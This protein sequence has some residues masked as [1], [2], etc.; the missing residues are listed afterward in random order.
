[1]RIGNLGAVAVSFGVLMGA[2]LTGCAYDEAAA[3]EDGALVEAGGL[4]QGEA[5]GEVSQALDSC[6]SSESGGGTW[7]GV[8]VLCRTS[9]GTLYVRKHDNGTFT[10]SGVMYLEADFANTI[11][12]RNVSDGV[13][14]VSFGWKPEDWY[15]ATYYPSSVGGIAYT[16]WLRN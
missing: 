2:T 9:T 4:E 12:S 7:G 16:G 1:M 5:V 6:T 11:W 8:I 14:S 13:T 15:R 10:S 3:E